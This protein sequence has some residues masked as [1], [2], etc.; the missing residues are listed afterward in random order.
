MKTVVKR[1]PRVT[2]A[3][4]L[5]GA[6]LGMAVPAISVAGDGAATASVRIAD[7][8]LSVKSG[9][10]MLERRTASAINKVCPL[11]GSI[12]GP[13]SSALK[14]HRECA[15]SVRNSVQEQ[16]LERGGRQVAG[17]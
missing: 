11:R 16:L 2:A 5:L 10:R 9:Q 3:A 8:N 1:I 15:Q 17:T 13:R 14:A 6:A 4:L 12:A 7:L